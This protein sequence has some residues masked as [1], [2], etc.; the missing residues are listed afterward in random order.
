[1]HF[2]EV[3]RYLAGLSIGFRYRKAENLTL[4]FF[5]LLF[6]YLVFLLCMIP[7]QPKMPLCLTFLPHTR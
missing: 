4:R 6:L 5:L 7:I 2:S 1:M 3:C